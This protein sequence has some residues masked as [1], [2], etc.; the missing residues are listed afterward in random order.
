MQNIMYVDC[1]FSLIGVQN[2]TRRERVRAED[3][4]DKA[5]SFHTDWI[6]IWLTAGSKWIIEEEKE[7]KNNTIVKIH[8]DRRTYLRSTYVILH[9][10]VHV[11]VRS[12][13][14]TE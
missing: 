8:A 7:T 3:R 4:L 11:Y 2:P 14:M 5:V 6:P 10:V 9:T 1:I 13:T 12:F